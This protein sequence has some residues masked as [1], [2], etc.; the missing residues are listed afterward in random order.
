MSG[1][2]LVLVGGG[3]AHL[4]IL[5]KLGSYTGRGHRVTLISASPYHYYSGMGPGLLAG[6]YRPQEAR[7]HVR[8]MAAAGGGEF[9]H[10]RVVRVD[11]Q[12]KKLLLAD[13][14]EVG[15]DIASF[16][17]GSEVPTA[18]VD[19]RGGEFA[20]VKPIENLLKVRQSILEKVSSTPLSLVVAGGGP[21]GIEIAG[22]LWRLLRDSGGKG[23]ITLVGGG[24]LLSGFPHEVRQKTLESFRQRGIVSME[25][26]RLTRLTEGKAQLSD[27]SGIDCDLAILATGVLP[28]PLFRDSG[29]PVGIDGGMLVNS[30][31]QCVEHPELFGG[32]DCICLQGSPLA[33]VGVYAVRQNP[34]LYA[35]LL[36]A[37]EEQPLEPFLPQKDYLLILNLGDGSGLLHRRGRVW[38]GRQPRKLKDFIDRR[39]MRS[40]QI[41]GEREE[42]VEGGA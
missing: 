2:H 27:D 18:R 42:S 40:F 25:G 14:L 33:R 4:T 3:H 38:H 36:A 16:N 28:S 9:V 11:P 8:A 20:T 5:K 1:R 13:G 10:G 17:V 37:L 6:T 35:N 29:L 23:E 21:A 32:G 31:L 15:Y 24:R 19:C 34:I 7:F 22:N 30:S 39:F 26:V 12:Q 41:S